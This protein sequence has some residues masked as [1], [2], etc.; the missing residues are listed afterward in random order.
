MAWF[1]KR[2]CR[3]NPTSHEHISQFFGGRYREVRK[4]LVDPQR[5]FDPS[6]RQGPLSMD[7]EKVA[8]WFLRSGR[9]KIDLSDRP[10]NRSRML[11]KGK[12][13]PENLLR[14]TVSDFFN[15]INVRRSS[16]W[17]ASGAAI[18]LLVETRRWGHRVLA[19]RRPSTVDLRL[20]RRKPP[21]PAASSRVRCT[22]YGSCL[23]SRPSSP[24]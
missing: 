12:R 23:V 4:P 19:D 21:S 7:V 1:R 20:A 14:K 2:S 13:P 17:T 5:S 24:G 15:S 10:I 3:R 18:Y 11:V 9:E 8:A 6:Y 22:R 16:V